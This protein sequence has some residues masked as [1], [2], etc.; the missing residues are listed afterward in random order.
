MLNWRTVRSCIWAAGAAVLWSVPSAHAGRLPAALRCQVAKLDAAGM[1]ARMRMFCEAAS[2][3]SGAT[4]DCLAKVDETLRL[5][6]ARADQGGACTIPGD[7]SDVQ[8]DLV[9]YGNNVVSSL[10]G[11]AG[12][13]PSRC[14]QSELRA[15]ARNI[16]ELA[17]ANAQNLRSPDATRLASDVASAAS[18][19]DAAFARARKS[20]DCLSETNQ[21]EWVSSLLQTEASRLVPGC[22]CWTSAGIDAAF[23]PGY[24]DGDGRGG[25]VCSDDATGVGLSTTDTCLFSAGMGGGLTLHLPRGSVG[26]SG[27]TCGNNLSDLD[28]DD[29]GQCNDVSLAVSIAAAQVKACVVEIKSSQAWQTE[30]P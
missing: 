25:A 2:V 8:T 4:P 28:P 11:G 5:A 21:S 3:A 22:P 10:R 19:L 24:F 29:D 15:A 14:T 9:N 16:G 13:A 12:P 6:F 7:A 26:V 1:A 20:R 23:P 30:C 18:R 27:T 17:R